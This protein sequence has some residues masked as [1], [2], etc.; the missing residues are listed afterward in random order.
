MTIT[1]PESTPRTPV[2]GYTW[3]EDRSA[4]ALSGRNEA[5]RVGAIARSI[6]Q[7]AVEILAGTRPASQLSRWTDP[8]VVERFTQRAAMLKLVQEQCPERRA[9]FEVHRAARIR[10]IR[11]CSPAPG[12]Y[13]ASLVVDEATRARAVALRIER[14]ARQWRVTHLEVG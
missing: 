2:G 13:E 8:E 10:R 12:C 14:V 6:G 1:V 11:M 9:V 3:R 7:A 5:E 4:A